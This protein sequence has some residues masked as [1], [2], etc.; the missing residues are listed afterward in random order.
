[1][2]LSSDLQ[3]LT[4]KLHKNAFGGRVQTGPAG[5]AIA[6]P[7]TLSRYK[8]EARKKERSGNRDGRKDV[9]R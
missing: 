7:R 1:V 8:G 6:L 3:I 2:K 5:G 4:C 9:K